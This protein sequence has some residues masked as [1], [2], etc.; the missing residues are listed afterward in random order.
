MRLFSVHICSILLLAL[1]ACGPKPSQQ[2]H[3]TVEPEGISAT[4]ASTEA[5]QDLFWN[6]LITLCGNAYEGA[7][8]SDDA[9]D[10]ELADQTMVMHVRRCTEDRIEIPFHIGDNRSRTWVLTRH[11][12]G[13]Q[14]QHDHR[15]EDGSED[16]VTL[17]GGRATDT[18]SQGVQ[19]FPADE[20]SK[21]LF[22]SN[23]LDVSV[24]NT[25]SLEI[26]PGKRF[27]YILRR[28]ERHFQADFD[29]SVTVDEPPP[30]WGH[31]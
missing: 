24:A 8:T 30:P 15:H 19:F 17:Y 4:E 29:L 3:R 6:H 31:S 13:L 14:L 25:W 7:M 20:Y 26:E 11:A 28:P 5:P 16:T 1:S 23:G 21:E 10:T 18:G 9:V 12:N 27:S 22:T 2:A